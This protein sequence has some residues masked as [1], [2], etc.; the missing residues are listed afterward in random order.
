MKN[1]IRFQLPIFIW[2]III[3][4][5]SSITKLPEINKTG[6]PVDKI[7][8]LIEY[9]LLGFLLARGLFYIPNKFINEKYL[10]LSITI[11]VFTGLI[12]EFY[13]FFVPGRDSNFLDFIADI[14]GVITAVYIFK[15]FYKDEGFYK[16]NF[17][18]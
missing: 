14:I 13:Q 18:G 12:D 3:F 7:F 15:K 6:I 17:P 10:I 8:H 11:A 9:F 2:A 5:C 4:L 16:E 1:I